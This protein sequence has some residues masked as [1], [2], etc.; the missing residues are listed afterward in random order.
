M[1]RNSAAGE[2]EDLPI[3]KYLGFRVKGRMIPHPQPFSKLEKGVKSGS[4]FLFIL[5]ESSFF[6]HLKTFKEE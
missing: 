1:G 3:K 5:R 2:P 4:S 6:K